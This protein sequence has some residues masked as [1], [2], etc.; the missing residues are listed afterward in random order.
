MQHLERHHLCFVF[1][2]LL[3][4]LYEN[5]VRNTSQSWAKCLDVQPD[6]KYN[7]MRTTQ[8]RCTLNG[9]IWWH[10]MEISVW[11]WCKYYL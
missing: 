10:E 5:V 11:T 1:K 7:N 4:T 9:G 8:S 6:T 2:V 3:S